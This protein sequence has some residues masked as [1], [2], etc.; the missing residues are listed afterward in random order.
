MPPEVGDLEESLM[1]AMAGD[2]RFDSGTPNRESD[3]VLDFIQMSGLAGRAES[4]PEDPFLSSLHG[5][6]PPLQPRHDFTPSSKPIRRSHVALSNRPMC[7]SSLARTI[8]LRIQRYAA[9]RDISPPL[10]S[11]SNRS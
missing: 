11:L 9:R 4:G 2:D 8:A 3:N 1:D 7:A 6:E 10:H 5:G